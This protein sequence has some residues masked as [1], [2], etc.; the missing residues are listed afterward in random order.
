MIKFRFI[1][2]TSSMNSSFICRHSIRFY[3]LIRYERDFY[4]EFIISEGF[5]QNIEELK[6]DIYKAEVFPFSEIS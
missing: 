6:C 5:Y 1:Q 4:A 3:H 2:V